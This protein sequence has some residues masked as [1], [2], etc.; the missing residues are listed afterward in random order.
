[1]QED[2]SKKQPLGPP[3]YSPNKQTDIRKRIGSRNLRKTTQ[4]RVQKLPPKGAPLVTETGQPAPPVGW[5]AYGVHP[6]ASP[7][8]VSFPPPLRVHLNRCSRSVHPT[9]IEE[10]DTDR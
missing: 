5:P 3:S 6:S 1:M 4:D 8:Y 10:V 7:F 9:M 2:L